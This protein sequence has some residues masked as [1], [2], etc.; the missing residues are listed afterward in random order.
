M[1][2]VL[3][4]KF[5]LADSSTGSVVYLSHGGLFL[6]SSLYFMAILWWITFVSWLC[7]PK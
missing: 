2:H 3:Q 5:I 7:L 1:I 4:H 6:S